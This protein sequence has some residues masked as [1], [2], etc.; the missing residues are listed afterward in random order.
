MWLYVNCGEHTKP[1]KP[2]IFW[3]LA[4]ASIFNVDFCC[5]KADMTVSKSIAKVSTTFFILVILT[6]KL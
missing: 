6:A 3:C 1:P 4:V 5:A 2:V